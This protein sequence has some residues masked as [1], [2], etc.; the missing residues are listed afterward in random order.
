MFEAQGRERRRLRGE[1]RRLA[2]VRAQ[3][4][5]L[6]AQL[7]ELMA[8]AGG[9]VADVRADTSDSRTTTTLTTN[10]TTATSLE[11]TIEP[12]VARFPP[13]SSPCTYANGGQA[14]EAKVKVQQLQDQHKGRRGQ[15]QQQPPPCYDGALA[16]PDTCS[17]MVTVTPPVL[18][19][20]GTK[21]K[22]ISINIDNDKGQA[23]TGWTDQSSRTTGGSHSMTNVNPTPTPVTTATTTAMMMAVLASPETATDGCEINDPHRLA[24]S[25]NS[26]DNSA[27]EAIAGERVQQA[28]PAI[29][30]PLERRR[31]QR[32]TGTQNHSPI[33]SSPSSLHGH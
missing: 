23:R 13:T 12:S 29:K 8:G 22:G 33:P 1:R 27:V 7:A 32:Q 3:R 21:E 14:G 26:S 24:N 28:A 17:L 18:R 15:Q 31:R 30:P 16:A 19:A 11:G 10:T 4:L 5:A 9:G 25:T 6:E 2:S 20:L